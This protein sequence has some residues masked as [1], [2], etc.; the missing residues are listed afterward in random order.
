[1][2]NDKIWQ[3]YI[4]KN[5]DKFISSLKS[6]DFISGKKEIINEK[7][8]DFLEPKKTYDC[9]RKIITQDAIKKFQNRF[10]FTTPKG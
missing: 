8:I 6:D 1:M 9:L 2:S 7:D 3:E 4:E 5:F 10:S